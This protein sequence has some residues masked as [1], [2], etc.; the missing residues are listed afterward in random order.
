MKLLPAVFI[1]MLAWLAPCGTADAQ[2]SNQQIIAA[3]PSGVESVI[4]ER[5]VDLKDPKSVFA[6]LYEPRHLLDEEYGK[7]TLGNRFDDL[8]P[9]VERAL[10]RA[11][12]RLKGT[13]G[14]D[15]RPAVHTDIGDATLRIIAVTEGPL[16]ALRQTLKDGKINGPLETLTID[17]ITVYHARSMHLDRRGAGQPMYTAIPDDHTVIMAPTEEEMRHMLT[18]LRSKPS[19]PKAVAPGTQ[20]PAVP[21]R[22]RSGAEG[23]NLEAP[24]VVLRSYRPDDTGDATAPRFSSATTKHGEVRAIGVSLDRVDEPAAKVRCIAPDPDAARAAYQ[25]IFA[26]TL[27]WDIKSKDGSFEGTIRLQ[28]DEPDTFLMHVYALWGMNIFI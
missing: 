10:V 11:G 26:N 14:S 28:R 5:V 2:L 3:M 12:L 8:R 9:V 20:A 7:E 17:S 25:G 19:D 6:K 18:C 15:F 21:E 23:L 16:S 4:I 24:L 27:R 1:G 13:G 22:W